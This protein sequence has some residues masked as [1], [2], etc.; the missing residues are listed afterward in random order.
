E[1]AFRHVLLR[2][3]AYGQIPRGARGEKH[4]RGATWIESLGRPE[5]HAEMLAHHYLRALQYT[6]AAGREDP[7]LVERAR[8]AL[9]TAGD[10]ALAL[11]AYRS[12]ARFYHAALELWPDDDG[13]R[14]WLVVLYGRANYGADRTGV[15]MLEQGFTE[16]R[17][18]GDANGA[19]EV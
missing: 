17:S 19:A 11:A 1:Y 15:E 14:V 10:R 6:T 9:R 3:V 4:Q 7:S 13:E 18:R 16:L 2:D 12:A 8:Y 5:D